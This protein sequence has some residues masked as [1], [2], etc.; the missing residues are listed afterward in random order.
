MPKEEFKVNFKV[1]YKY[2]NRPEGQYRGFQMENRVVECTA[3]VC[4]RL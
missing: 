1:R 2:R 4:N 3:K